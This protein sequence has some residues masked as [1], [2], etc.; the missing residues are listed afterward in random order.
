M[1][2]TNKA[3]A[4]RIIKELKIRDWSQIE[5]LK[6]IIKFK[7]PSLSKADIY[8]EAISKKANF[9]TSLKGSDK[10]PISKED[11]YVI[12]K[13]FSLPLEYI[14][15]GEEKKSG[16]IPTGARYAAFQDT[17]N[18]YRTYIAGLEHED[19]VQHADETG[20]NLFDY[21]AEF[22]SINGY[23]FFVNNYNLHFDY[24]NHGE[25][26]YINKDGFTQFC[27]PFKRGNLMSDNLISVLIKFKDTKS[28]RVV[29]FDNCSLA[30]FDSNQMSYHDKKL[31]GDDFLKQL[32][33]NE[34]FLDFVLEPKTITLSKLDKRYS[35]NEARTFV[36]PMFYEALDYAMSHQSEYRSSLLKMLKFALDYD[37][38]QYEFI[39][40]YLES[41]KNDN[42]GYRD[43][44]IDIYNPKFLV[45]SFNRTM[46]NI[47]TIK[48]I[49]DDS[50]I[51][52]LIKQI[53]LYAFNITHIIND[54]ERDKEGLK[55]STPDNPLFLELHDNAINQNAD[56]VPCKIHSTKEFT[57]FEYYDSTEIGFGST[58]H[59]A[60]LID[61]LDK[62]QKLVQKKEGKVLVHGNIREAKFMT[63]KGKIIGLAGWQHCHYGD[64][65]EDKAEALAE[66]KDYFGYG[67]KF[68]PAYKE[69][70]D[71]ISKGFTKDEQIILINRAIN[72]LDKERK[73][74][75][76]DEHDYLN[77]VSLLKE[78]SSRL[79]LFKE[80][81]L[82]K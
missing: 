11:L 10:R 80:Q 58:D 60:L 12:S 36:E 74:L 81:Y 4:K 20:H 77:K 34:S 9:S 68:L 44:S 26:V 13:V 57:S 32:L 71:V 24:A 76:K 66:I 47:I 79:E 16:F 19:M 75:P 39:K 43:V 52:E 64:K 41:H 62:A 27:M 5:L 55:I 48:G 29:Y 8:Y 1:N 6:R 7:N 22:E 63:S 25:M 70:F 78:R 23:R 3:I 30:R 31:F 72:I 35:S 42:F 46:G 53:E 49:V 59:M 17:E 56:F 21:F 50:E 15:F 38:S 69:I 65:Y 61:F 28:F 37:K 33:E 40:E 2:D 45:S 14:W 67:S 54:Q 51:D 73:Q 18:E 82:E